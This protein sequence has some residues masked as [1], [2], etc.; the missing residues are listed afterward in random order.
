MIYGS[1]CWDINEKN[2]LKV[3]VADMRTLKYICGVTRL[4]KTR[5]EYIRESSRATNDDVRNIS[6]WFEHVER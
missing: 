5:N 3:K 6:R 2:E 4:D 1:E